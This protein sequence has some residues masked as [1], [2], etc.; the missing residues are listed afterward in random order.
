MRNPSCGW[1][2]WA[3]A[4]V[5]AA[6]GGFESAPLQTGTV[7]GRI[8]GA[9]ADVA[10]VSVLG[11]SEGSTPGTARRAWGRCPPAATRWR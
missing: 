8:L 1:A 9:E 10:R 2:G 6:W 11:R 7:R 5:L 3:L 4:L